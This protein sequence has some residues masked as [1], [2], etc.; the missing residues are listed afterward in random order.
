MKIFLGLIQIKFRT[1][2]A[3]QPLA[4]VFVFKYN[5]LARTQA[6]IQRIIVGDGSNSVVRHSR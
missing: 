1:T 4:I 6:T 3:G 2:R 5:L